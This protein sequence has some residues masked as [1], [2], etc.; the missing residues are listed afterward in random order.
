VPRCCDA[1]LVHARLDFYRGIVFLTKG[2]IL[3]EA[4]RV[5]EL[6]EA[7]GPLELKPVGV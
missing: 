6:M 7:A 1:L 5:A 3:N 2:F 4:Y